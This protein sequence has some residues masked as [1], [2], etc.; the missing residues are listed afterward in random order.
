MSREQ[1][2]REAVDR[3][4]ARIRQDADKHLEALAAEL[5]VV[6]R[7]DIHTSRLDVERAAVDV[8]R[9]VAKGG[10]H[11]RRDLVVR[12]IDAI[13]RLDEA[14]SLGGII[15]ALALGA[16]AEAARVAVLMVDD[17]TLRAW[18]HHGFAP[19]QAPRDIAAS[20]SPVL[21]AALKLR[22][23]TAVPGASGAPDI[24]IPV[25][26]HPPAGHIGL[27]L[28]LVVGK[29]VVAL[30]Y[31]DGADRSASEPGAPVWNDQV[32]VLVRHASARL[33]NVT[34]QRTVEVLTTQS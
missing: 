22:Q 25:F 34:S 10:S 5:L 13:R 20:A 16:A 6:A 21:A 27:I 33:E 17:Q 15:D 28:P 19:G 32:E 11:A 23:I 24:T 12:I 8:A 1:E 9:A 18:R 31:A 26:M 30:V 14:T 4:T 29:D 3:F 7:G 2:V